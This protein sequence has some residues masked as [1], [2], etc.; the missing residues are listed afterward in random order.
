MMTYCPV[1]GALHDD[2]GIYRYKGVA[3]F[4]CF[5]C[6]DELSDEEI[7]KKLDEKGE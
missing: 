2:G 6:V 3:Y 4:L 5:D 7:E 1:C